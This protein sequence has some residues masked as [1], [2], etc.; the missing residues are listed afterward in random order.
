MRLYIKEARQ[1]VGLNQKQLAEALG[2][3]ANTLNGYESGAHDP[4]SDLLCRIA[5]ICGVTVDYLLGLEK[6]N[7]PVLSDEAKMIAEQFDKASPA[8]KAAA[9]AVLNSER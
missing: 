7:R 1:K 9:K 4:K 5:D 8:I 3:A 6:E 2:V